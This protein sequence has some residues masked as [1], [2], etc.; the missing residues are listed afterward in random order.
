MSVKKICDNCGT[1]TEIRRST[2]P[3]GWATVSCSSYGIAKWAIRWEYDFC[4]TCINALFPEAKEQSEPS[5]AKEYFE[6]S[7]KDY[8]TELVDEAVEDRA[9]GAAKEQYDAKR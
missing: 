3:L 5:T 2:K 8:L 9:G 7:F 4:E 1:E 6:E